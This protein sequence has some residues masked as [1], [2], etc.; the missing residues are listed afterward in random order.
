MV[1]QSAEHVGENIEAQ[2]H[3]K[4]AVGLHLRHRRRDIAGMGQAA[5]DAR[6]TEYPQ[7]TGDNHQ[8]PDAPE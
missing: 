8:Q 3:F 7:Q 5:R 1:R 6:P 2:T 4:S